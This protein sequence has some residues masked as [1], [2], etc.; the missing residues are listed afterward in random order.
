MKI[1]PKDIHKFY[2]ILTYFGFLSRCMIEVKVLSEAALISWA[3][4]KYKLITDSSDADFV[5]CLYDIL[6]DLFD[7]S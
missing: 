2:S 1:F 5:Y 7:W 3:R 4:I 6:T